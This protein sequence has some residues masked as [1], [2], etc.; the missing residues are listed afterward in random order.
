[1]VKLLLD[2]PERAALESYLRNRPP[3]ASSGLAIVEVT[4]AAVIA[5]PATGLEEADRLLK[6]C[7]LVEIDDAILDHAKRLAGPS[8]RALDAIHLASAL[9]VG[10]EELVA[11]DHRLLAG[12][13]RLGLQ[14]A[15]PGT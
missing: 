10:P 11:Y 2:E 13:A 6:A 3:L 7:E 12:A 4:R 14:T 15:S 8:L 9:L 5:N 1:L